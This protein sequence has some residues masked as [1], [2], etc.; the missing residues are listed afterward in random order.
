MN[1]DELLHDI[2]KL[3][4]ERNMKI[5]SL[6]ITDMYPSITWDIIEPKLIKLNVEPEII[7]LIEFAY[8]SNYFEYQGNYYTQEEGISMGS[9][10]GPKLA[11]MVMIDIDKKINNIHGINFYK[12]YVDDIIIIYDTSIITIDKINTLINNI[13]NNIKFKIE[14]EDTDKSS[15]IVIM[16]LHEL[17]IKKREIVSEENFEKLENDPFI[18]IQ[19]ALAKKLKNLVKEGYI[20]PYQSKK[21]FQR[22]TITNID[23]REK[24][25]EDTRKKYILNEYPKRLL[26]DWY[27]RFLRYRFKVKQRQEIKQ[28]APSQNNRLSN[29]MIIRSTNK[30]DFLEEDGVVYRIECTCNNPSFYIGETKRRLKI[31]L[32][33]HLA[34]V[35][36][37]I[38]NSLIFQHCNI[39][40]CQINVNKL[41]I[42]FRG[43][44][45]NVK[46]KVK[47]HFA[48]VMQNNN[49]NLNTGML[50][51]ECWEFF[52]NYISGFL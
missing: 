42:V 44:K 29:M 35:R 30:K 17:R 22:K 40:N 47:E 37:K 27:N 38:S 14:E 15:Q 41:K 46:R 6:D 45:N 43:K 23:Q 50:T 2:K 28:L 20:M 4:I 52:V 36:L 12:R 49:V 3:K 10:I 21:Y 39:N 1:T 18:G 7:N 51:A 32:S 24:E 25:I 9:V 11:E 8:K 13:Q 19:R 34:A 26:T 16:D 48:I 5:A 33:E 31:R